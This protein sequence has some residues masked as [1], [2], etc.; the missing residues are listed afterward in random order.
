[1]ESK[2]NLNISNI[3]Y[4]KETYVS[5]VH[6]KIF[7]NVYKTLKKGDEVKLL[8]VDKQYIFLHHYRLNR[9]FCM[10]VSEHKDKLESIKEQRKNKLNIIYENSL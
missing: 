1:M 3:Y 5:E 7:K 2:M 6:D 8:Q 9:L 10:E 4:L